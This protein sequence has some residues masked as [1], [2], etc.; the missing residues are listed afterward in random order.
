MPH[1]NDLRACLEEE[2]GA[3]GGG[4]HEAE[5][6]ESG[7]DGEGAGDEGHDVGDGGQRDGHA[8]VLQGQTDLA[9]GVHARGVRG[10]GLDVAEALHDHEHVVDA[11]SWFDEKYLSL[12]NK[13]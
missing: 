10:G 2:Y 5:V 3:D 4:G 12:M 11:N 1:N 8:R 13:H 9:L 6:V 7:E